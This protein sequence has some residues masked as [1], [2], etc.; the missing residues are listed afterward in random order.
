MAFALGP[1]MVTSRGGC[2]AVVLD[3]HR[4]MVAGGQSDSGRLNT[5][6]I[7]DV[8][9]MAFAPGPRMGSARLGCAAV[10]VDAQH[11]L[12]IGG[13]DSSGTLATTKALDVAALEFEDGP[14]LLAG[15]WGVAATRLDATEGEPPRI[16]VMGGKDE[17]GAGLPTTEVLIVDPQRSVR[18]ARRHGNCAS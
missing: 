11:V 7:L 17:Y 10:A 13:E 14:A 9:T 4:V 5:T 6:E 15:R 2:A 8:R 12:I 3:E 16:L 1:A 18:A